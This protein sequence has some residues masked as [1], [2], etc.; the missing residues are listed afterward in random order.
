MNIK[1]SSATYS[2]F[3]FA[4]FSYFLNKIEVPQ[5]L[6]AHHK[7]EQ[8][9]VTTLDFVSFARSNKLL[10]TEQF[11]QHSNI[12]SK[13]TRNWLIHPYVHRKAFTLHS[14]ISVQWWNGDISTH[15]HTHP[16]G[17][18]Y[19]LSRWSTINPSQHTRKYLSHSYKINS[20]TPVQN[21]NTVQRKY[22]NTA[23]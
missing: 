6:V 15:F 20:I 2:F 5:C 14:I 1:Y 18:I 4:H 21:Y 7:E 9:S 22:K 12:Q 17:Y 8:S 16:E 11:V 19:S 23:H 3:F 10:F 13:H